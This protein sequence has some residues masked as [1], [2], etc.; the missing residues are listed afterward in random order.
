MTLR[1]R[2]NPTIIFNDITKTYGD[3]DFVVTATSNSSGALIYAVSN[4][5]IASTS[6]STISINEAGTSIVTVNQAA[7]GN[8]NSGIATMTLLV[9]KAD[10]IIA[11]ID[12]DQR[13]TETLDFNLSATSSSTGEFTFSIADSSIAT[14]SGNSVTITGV[15]STVVTVN[16]I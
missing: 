11:F 1:V 6:A 10:P 3:P 8:F 15:G 2:M 14:V 7:A 9:N 12:I 5:S 16:Q 4:S 13:L